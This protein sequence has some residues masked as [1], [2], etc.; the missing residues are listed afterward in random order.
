MRKAPICSAVLCLA[1]ALSPAWAGTVYVP[2]VKSAN[3]V[4]QSTE[5]FVSNSSTAARNFSTVFLKAD[6]NGTVRQGTP[7]QTAVVGNGLLRLPSGVTAGDS[8]LLEVNAATELGIAAR[9][10]STSGNSVS[11]ARLPVISS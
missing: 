10:V 8:G 9:L 3:G 11:E 5:V 2:V 1:G 6:T 7:G 4:T